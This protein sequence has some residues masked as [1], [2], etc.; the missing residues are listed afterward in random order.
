MTH[1]RIKR[2]RRLRGRRRRNSCYMEACVTGG[3]EEWMEEGRKE[4]IQERRKEE[5]N[6][7][8]KKKERKNDR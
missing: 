3:R 6:E 5:I 2:N 8:S 4:G 7:G 1:A